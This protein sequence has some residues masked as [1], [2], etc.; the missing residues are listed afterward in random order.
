MLQKSTTKRENTAGP[1][2][3]H[4][5]KYFNQRQVLTEVTQIFFPNGKNY[6]GKVNTMDSFLGNYKGEVVQFEQLQ[7]YGKDKPHLYVF[8][9]QKVIYK[10][11]LLALGCDFQTYLFSLD[12]TLYF[13]PYFMIH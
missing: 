8:T 6:K 7:D 3:V 2:P 5:N 12:C 4:I 11:A 10:E 1:R 13:Y 9:K